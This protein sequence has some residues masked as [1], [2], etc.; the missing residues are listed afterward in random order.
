MNARR[1]ACLPVIVWTGLAGDHA[2]ASVRAR[3]LPAS[4]QSQIV[5][6]ADNLTNDEHYL[7]VP[8]Q[9]TKSM[10]ALWSPWISANHLYGISGLEEYD[11]DLFKKLSTKPAASPGTAGR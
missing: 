9:D 2:I 5:V 3:W 6:L 4:G 8:L 7:G 11:P 1:S 10:V